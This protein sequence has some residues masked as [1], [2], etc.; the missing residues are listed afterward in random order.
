VG[1]TVSAGG[2]RVNP[3]GVLTHLDI[4]LALVALAS[5][6]KSAYN[7]WVRSLIDNIQMISEVYTKTEELEDTQGKLV[8]AVVALSIA[9]TDDSRSV[10]PNEV[11]ATL[12]ENG[13]VRDYLRR[14]RNS[15]PPY[16]DVEDEEVEIPEEERRWRENY[17]DD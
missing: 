2:F 8:D 17:D 7:G 6:A 1:V 5:A 16:G 14:D 12:R 10:D 9:E 3:S 4:L 11:E 13:S 15:T